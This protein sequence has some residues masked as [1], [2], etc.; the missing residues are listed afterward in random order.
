MIVKAKHNCENKLQDKRYGKGMRVMNPTV[1][2]KLRC[3]V[4][5]KEQE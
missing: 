5:G 3:T 1:T 2:D 4:C